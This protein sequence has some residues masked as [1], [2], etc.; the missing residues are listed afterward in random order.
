MSMKKLVFHYFIFY[1]CSIN[2]AGGFA[3][4]IY[5]GKRERGGGTKNPPRPAFG[6][7]R[8]KAREGSRVKALQNPVRMAAADRF[9]IGAWISSSSPSCFPWSPFPI[10]QSNYPGFLPD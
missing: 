4:W 3:P 8:V 9:E 5:T 2:R 1:L 6:Q 7:R 10:S